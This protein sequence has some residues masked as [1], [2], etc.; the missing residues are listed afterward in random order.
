ANGR[1]ER[2]DAKTKILLDF[3]SIDVHEVAIHGRDGALVVPEPETRLEVIANLRHPLT[4]DRGPD[5]VVDPERQEVEV[6]NEDVLTRAVPNGARVFLPR[7][8][9]ADREGQRLL[10]PGRW[11]GCEHGEEQGEHG[12]KSGAK[13]GSAPSTRLCGR[14]PHHLAKQMRCHKSSEFSKE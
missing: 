14:G 3:R 6:V 8:E 10:G 9:A 1:R 7:H 4:V 12:Q 11:Y 2:D 13:H 5:E